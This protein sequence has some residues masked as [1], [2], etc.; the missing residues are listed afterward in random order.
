MRFT[1][2][3]LNNIKDSYVQVYVD[4]WY[5]RSLTEVGVSVYY[6]EDSYVQEHVVNM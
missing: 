6:N 3:C 2:A 4:S 5:T 1:E